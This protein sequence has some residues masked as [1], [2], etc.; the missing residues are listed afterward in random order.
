[1]SLAVFGRYHTQS[2]AGVIAS[3]LRSAGF[4]PV[5]FDEHYGGVIWTAQT[6]LGGYRLMLPNADIEPALAL[7]A[8]ARA[9][10]VEDNPEVNA[11]PVDIS[12]PSTVVYLLALLTM[13]PEIGWLAAPALRRR[14]PR[15]RTIIMTCIALLAILIVLWTNAFRLWGMTA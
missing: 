11:A 5:V 12:P 1:M 9:Q 13:G 14:G 15:L 6:A 4:A 3:L 7:L 8:E 2:E 10:A